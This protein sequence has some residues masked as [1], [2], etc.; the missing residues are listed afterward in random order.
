[1]NL[2]PLILVALA[3]PPTSDLTVIRR[4]I[5]Q[6]Q[7]Q[8]FAFH[9]SKGGFWYGSPMLKNMP[10]MRLDKDALDQVCPEGPVRRES[11]AGKDE[12]L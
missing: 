10:P 2:A 11:G 9:D 4:C 6:L 3:A 1:M 12:H 7:V 5:D 8:M